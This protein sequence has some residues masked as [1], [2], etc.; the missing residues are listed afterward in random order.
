MYRN[1]TQYAF[2]NS[3]KK[4]QKRYGTR[5]AYARMEQA[6]DRY[7]LTAREALFIHARDSFYMATVGE[8]GWPYVQFRGGEKGFLRVI[9]DTT[10]GYADFH[11]NGQYISTGNI[12]ANQ[13]TA[14]ILMDYPNQQRLKIWAEATIDE[15]DDH[16]EVL[17]QLKIPAY[18]GHIERLVTLKIKAFDWNCPRHITPRYTVEEIHSLAAVE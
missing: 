10:I 12:E 17:E 3:V 6:G 15:A 14:L 11:G 16:P 9:D 2:T 13:K 1:F 8:N 4:A 5:D 7:R 18:E